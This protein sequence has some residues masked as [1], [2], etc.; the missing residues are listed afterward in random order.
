MMNIKYCQLMLPDFGASQ[1]WT[2]GSLNL[3]VT[4][5]DFQGFEA[6]SFER[7]L[8]GLIYHKAYLQ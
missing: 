4:L 8:T 1:R 5:I 6:T 2:S 7:Y 3:Y